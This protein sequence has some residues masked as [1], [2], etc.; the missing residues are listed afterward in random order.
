M[1]SVGEHGNKC[2]AWVA[3]KHKNKH[4]IGRFSP[5]PCTYLCVRQMAQLEYFAQQVFLL[6]YTT[7][8]GF[9]PT[10]VKLNQTGTFEGCST[11]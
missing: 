7:A 6:S 9:E 1:P 10:S 8:L 3:K 11:D 2:E 5:I 4:V